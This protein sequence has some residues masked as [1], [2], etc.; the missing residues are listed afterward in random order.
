MTQLCPEFIF[1]LFTRLVQMC[2]ACF[3]LWVFH[4]QI[5]LVSCIGSRCGASLCPS[6]RESWYMW[7]KMFCYP[8]YIKNQ[9]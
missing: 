5:F 8:L 3:F 4:T 1:H 6:V 9:W 7:I 2:S